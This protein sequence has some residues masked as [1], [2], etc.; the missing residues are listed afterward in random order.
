MPG[1]PAELTMSDQQTSGHATEPAS[2]PALSTTVQVIVAVSLGLATVASAW[3]AYESAVWSGH[4]ASETLSAGTASALATQESVKL[5]RQVTVDVSTFLAWAQA[6]DAGNARLAQFLRARMR[7][8]LSAAVDQWLATVPRGTVPAGTPFDTG[9]EPPAA[10]MVTRYRAEAAHHVETANAA[11]AISDRY[12][13]MTVIMAMALFFVGISSQFP[14]RAVGKS[15]L[16]IGELL[17]AGGVVV[18]LLMPK[19][20]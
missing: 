13:L 5:S 3:C 10:A 2:E 4:Q 14:R 20:L 19:L 7:A 12:T 9:Y 16:G 18:I 1:G 6:I 15:V 17:W 11:N 8:E